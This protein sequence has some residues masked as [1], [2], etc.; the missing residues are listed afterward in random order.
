MRG[1]I[2]LLRRTVLGKHTMRGRRGYDGLTLGDCRLSAPLV[3][4]PPALGQSGAQGQVASVAEGPDRAHGSIGAHGAVVA[5]ATRF[6]H[7]VGQAGGGSVATYAA[8]RTSTTLGSIGGVGQAIT[9]LPPGLTRSAS[10]IVFYD[11]FNRADGALGG[12]WVDDAGTW[13][14][15]SGQATS[16]GGNYDRA[17]NTGVSLA[18]GVYEARLK[19]PSGGIYCGLR[20]L[21]PSSADDYHVFLKGDNSDKRL[22]RAAASDTTIASLTLTE[23][24]NYHVLKVRY[25]GTRDFVVWWDHAAGVL[26]SLGTPFNAGAGP[27]AAGAVGLIGY[28]GS[29]LVDWVLVSTD[30]IITMTG[31]SG[32]QGF[33]ILDPSDVVIG[34]SG[35]QSGGTATLDV[36]TLFDGRFAGYVQMY[37]DA[38]TW[39]VP[40]SNGRYPPVTGNANDIAGGDSYHPN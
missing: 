22:A 36:A 13:S 29:P 25:S 4:L 26:G 34:S 10:G 28:G 7:A 37:D 2:V 5:V 9:T 24:L 39:A 30:H 38:G 18:A 3:R 31:L 27:T 32:S 20:L 16:S 33:R 21:A 6:L 17:R 19:A 14:I 23:D 40:N 1:G 11:D 8:V 12:N 35:T 15:S